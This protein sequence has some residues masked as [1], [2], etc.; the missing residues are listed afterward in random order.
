MADMAWE[1][2]SVLMAKFEEESTEAGFS[3]A[4]RGREE[5]RPP[6][7]DVK[8]FSWSTPTA[9]SKFCCSDRSI[10]EEEEGKCVLSGT[11]ELTLAFK[12][13]IF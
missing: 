1:K 9:P 7:L 8:S 12:S 10:A 6:S 11:S 13:S 2:V 3:G 4:Y 5:G